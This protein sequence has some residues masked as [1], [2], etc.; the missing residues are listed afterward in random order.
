MALRA[1]TA[2]V[3]VSPHHDGPRGVGIVTPLHKGWRGQHRR[4]AARIRQTTAGRVKR[5]AEFQHFNRHG[6]LVIQ[7]YWL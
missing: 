7:S 4:T 6:V 1:F 2:S 5:V 3:P